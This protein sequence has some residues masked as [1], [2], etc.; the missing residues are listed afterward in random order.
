MANIT[1]TISG[2]SIVGSEG[3]DSIINSHASDVTIQTFGGRD[4]IRNSALDYANKKAYGRINIDSGDDDDVISHTGDNYYSGTGDLYGTINA[5]AGNDS[6]FLSYAHYFSV[7]AGDGNDT[8]D[9][10][11][12]DNSTINLGEGDNYLNGHDSMRDM[13]IYAGSGNDTIIEANG[14]TNTSGVISTG[15]GKDYIFR[16]K[17]RIYSGDGADTILNAYA[18]SY[19]NAGADDDYIANQNESDNNNITIKPGL[20]NDTVD[21]DAAYGDP[22][23]FNVIQYADGDGN[24]QIINF[25]NTD[26]LHI[27]SGSIDSFKYA[28]GK[29]LVKVGNGTISLQT[30]F[31]YCPGHSVYDNHTI[32][33]V[34]YVPVQVRDSSGQMSVPNYDRSNYVSST[35]LSGTSKA[36]RLFNGSN[37]RATINAG[38]GNDTVFN[39][40]ATLTSINTGKGLDTVYNDTSDNVTIKTGADDD[41]VFNNESKNTLIFLE[42]GNDKIHSYASR[43][44]ISAGNGN[45]YVFY[46]GNINGSRGSI[47]GGKG[48]DTIYNGGSETTIDGGADNDY[49]ENTGHGK[50]V[51]IL[52]GEGDD[53]IANLSDSDTYYDAGNVTVDGGIGNDTI[54]NRGNRALIFGGE[55]NDSIYNDGSGE[56]SGYRATINGG[57]DDDY[58]YNKGYLASIDGRVGNDTIHNEG[59]NATINGGDGADSIL[60]NDYSVKINGGLG[61]DWIKSVDSGATIDGGDNDDYIEHWSNRI[62]INGGAG[63][64]TIVGQSATITIDGGDGDDYIKDY[65]GGKNV[66]INGGVG[67]DFIDNSGSNATIN[68][69][70]DNDTVENNGA[71]S[72]I[73]L[74]SGA[75]SIAN[76]I[77][78]T[79][80][81]GGENNDSIYNTYWDQKSADSVSIDAGEGDNFIDNR[82]AS[83][84]T[85]KSGAG[86]DE[87]WA[88]AFEGKNFDHLTVDVGAGDDFVYIKESSYST[89]NLGDGNDTIDHDWSRLNNS[90]NNKNLIEGGEGDDYILNSAGTNSTFLGGTGNDTIGNGT[91]AYEEGA[92]VGAPVAAPNGKLVV[93][94]DG[95]DVLENGGGSN[96]TLDGGIGDDVINN[97]NAWYRTQKVFSADNVSI[98][99]GDGADHITD[100]GTDSTISGGTG[101]DQISLTAEHSDTTIQYKNGDGNDTVYGFLSSDKLEITG[102]TSNTVTVGNDLVVNV[103]S[104]SITFKDFDVKQQIAYHTEGAGEIFNGTDEDDYIEN[105]SDNVTID[106]RGGNDTVFSDGG[107]YMSINGGADNDYIDNTGANATIDGGAGDDTILVFSDHSTISG[108]DGRDTILIAVTDYSTIDAGD[109]DD[110]VDLHSHWCSSNPTV[111]SHYNVVKL[112]NGNDFIQTAGYASTV[113]GGSGDDTIDNMINWGDRGSKAGDKSSL[114]G[115]DGSDVILNDCVDVTINGGAGNDRVTLNNNH[116][117]TVIEYAAGDGHDTIY[118]FNSSDKLQLTGSMSTVTVGNNIVVTVNVG[119]GSITLVDAADGR[120]KQ[121]IEPL[122]VGQAIFNTLDNQLI[123]TGSGRDSIISYGNNVTIQGNGAADTIRIE[124]CEKVIIDV[125]D[126]DDSIDHWNGDNITIRG[127]A[128]NDH[129]QNDAEGKKTYVDAGAGNDFVWNYAGDTTLVGGDGNDE[130]KYY[131]W[132]GSLVGGKGDDKIDNWAERTMIDGG[133]GD[134]TINNG[135]G[136]NATIVGGAGN[137]KIEMWSSAKQSITGGDGNDTI[138]LNGGD[139]N[140]LI[141]G[142]GNDYIENR[143]DWGENSQPF[144]QPNNTF[145]D[146]GNGNDTIG[147]H[148]SNVTIKTGAGNDHVYNNGEWNLESGEQVFW[149]DHVSIDLGDGDDTLDQWQGTRYVTVRGGKGNDYL[150]NR[151]AEGSIDGGDGDDFIGNYYDASLTAIN[152]GADNDSIDNSVS[153]VTILGGAGNDSINSRAEYVTI[154]GGAGNDIVDIVSNYSKNQLIEYGNGDGNDTVYGFD[155]YDT[156]RITSGSIASTSVVGADALL[157]IGNGSVLLKNAAGKTINLMNAAGSVTQTVIGDVIRGTEN[158]DTLDANRSPVIVQPLIGDDIV[159][160]SGSKNVVDYAGGNDTVFGL[161]SDDTV[162]IEQWINTA[163][164]DGNDLIFNTYWSVNDNWNHGLFTLKDAADKSIKM[165]SLDG[166]T[167]YYT[168]NVDINVDGISRIDNYFDDLFIDEEK[169]IVRLHNSGDNVTIK[170]DGPISSSGINVVIQRIGT[171]EYGGIQV[172][173]GDPENPITNINVSLGDGGDGIELAIGVAR[174]EGR[175]DFD[176]E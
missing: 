6:I 120:L 115:G 60:S 90:G 136:D 8:V 89:I 164:V 35:V 161:T 170:S 59:S 113:D 108:G 34:E 171:G 28:D 17:G 175:L 110:S 79:T 135:H 12:S 174:V 167:L 150:I 7:D 15:G 91:G 75:N 26:I 27:T 105:H 145:I 146:G 123:K 169:N 141:G 149:A 97:K 104:G 172:G 11:S 69:G 111:N 94:G 142:E 95:H 118:G 66:S 71:N 93:G 99:G 39:N 53:F 133:D 126:G 129:I 92:S 77:Y 68:A 137:D 16:S 128:G 157:K 176:R 48:N 29:Y 103:G 168:P 130:I 106:A 96:V 78:G 156:L 57:V 116:Y 19:V 25:D 144:N 151:G 61:K 147:N 101:D 14:L 2:A 62:S 114:S 74:G 165:I 30:V 152:G 85:I 158:N 41:Y 153:D 4:T 163:S 154:N 72:Y 166:R 86:K 173:G 148:G 13:K 138:S 122:K 109:G 36:D 49:I 55:G 81:V 37:N 45:D 117:G 24:D 143:T 132:T 87:V 43:A 134:D 73:D 33:S 9:G 125:G 47:D 52:G 88:W 44:S 100:S 31:Q 3:N 5:G 63:N 162:R 131:G 155:E 76:R 40:Y 10:G 107:N 112:G 82:G 65:G 139:E 102:G 18:N 119:E 21:F 42:D 80:I 51:S 32:A 67:N 23:S 20:G 70:T 159:S 84:V 124:K 56:V 127:G 38:D 58:I 54:S 98:N 22:R 83:Y 121:K 160:L 140:T 64:D 50:Y 1:N 46:H